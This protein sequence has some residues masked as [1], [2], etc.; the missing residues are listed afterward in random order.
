MM[1]AMTCIRLDIAYV[2]GKMSEYTNNLDHIHWIVVRMIL[3]YLKK[4]MDYNILYSGYLSV[5]EGYMYGC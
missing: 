1:Y 2:V 5:L 4:I 3:K